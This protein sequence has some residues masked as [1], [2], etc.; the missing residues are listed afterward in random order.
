MHKALK[1]LRVLLVPQE[2]QVEQG[3]PVLKAHKAHKVL[4]DPK[5]QQVLKAEQGLLEP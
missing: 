2:L 5:V 4:L 3:L 1:V